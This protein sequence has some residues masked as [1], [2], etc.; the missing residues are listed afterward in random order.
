LDFNVL[1]GFVGFFLILCSLG[2]M[3]LDSVAEDGGLILGIVFMLLGVALLYSA[4][5][6]L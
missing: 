4:I 6:L 5:F 1:V 3:G 2:L